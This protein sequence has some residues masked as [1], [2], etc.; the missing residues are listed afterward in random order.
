LLKMMEKYKADYTN[1][2]RSLTL[3]AIENTALFE[4]PEFKEWYKMW[5]SR[6]E[7]QDES[8]ENA[9]EMMKNNNPSIIP[10]NHRVEEALEAAVTNGDYSVMEKLLEALANPYAYATDQE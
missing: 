9:Y 1:T 10:R 4:S 6:L 2:F 7:R 3:D 5:Q 8:K